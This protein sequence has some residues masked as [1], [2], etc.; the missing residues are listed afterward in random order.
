MKR[1][2]LL[3]CLIVLGIF[4]SCEQEP[5]QEKVSGVFSVTIV[6]KSEVNLNIES[7]EYFESIGYTFGDWFSV[8]KKGKFIDEIDVDYELLPNHSKTIDI[9]YEYTTDW[10]DEKYFIAKLNCT[11]GNNLIPIVGTEKNWQSESYIRPLLSER[12]LGLKENVSLQ[13]KLFDSEYFLV[14]MNYE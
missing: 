8:D 11:Y 4:T 2:I 10:T 9:P 7:L 12:Y 5:K 14:Y 6:N 3:L 1:K 13:F